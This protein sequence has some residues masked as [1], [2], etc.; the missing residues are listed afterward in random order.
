MAKEKAK[1]EPKI[2]E[3]NMAHFKLN[4]EVKRVLSTFTD[5]AARKLYLRNMIK[6]QIVTETTERMTMM[7][8]VKEGETK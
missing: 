5:K 7:Y 8:D 1:K 6:A 4:K 3:Y 2:R